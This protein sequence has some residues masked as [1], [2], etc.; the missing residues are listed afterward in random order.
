MSVDKDGDPFYLMRVGV[1]HKVYNWNF[2]LESF[3][4]LKKA[5]EK[6]NF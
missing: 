4:S 1:I 3:D 6:R 5:I 2:E